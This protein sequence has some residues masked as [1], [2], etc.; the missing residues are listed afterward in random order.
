MVQLMG[1]IDQ[2]INT[3]KSTIRSYSRKYNIPYLYDSTT[4][5][6][7][8]GKNQNKYSSSQNGIPIV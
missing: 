2:F 7:Q 6:C 5:I 1:L 4:D 3:S 8:R